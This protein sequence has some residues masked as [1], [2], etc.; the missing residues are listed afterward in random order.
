MTGRLIGRAEVN[1]CVHPVDPANP[2]IPSAVS[3]AG[4]ADCSQFDFVTVVRHFGVKPELR[5]KA[6]VESRAR[7]IFAMREK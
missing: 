3:A 2:V 4:A 1:N 7:P 5:L 6:I